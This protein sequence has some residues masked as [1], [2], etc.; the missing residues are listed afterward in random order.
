VFLINGTELP[1]AGVYRETL[2][3]TD[4]NKET[5][6][7]TVTLRC[8]DLHGFNIVLGMPWI[9][10]AQ[11]VFHWSAREW[12]YGSDDDGPKVRILAPQPFYASMRKP[13]ARLHAVS[14]APNSDHP[15][16]VALEAREEAGIPPE[17]EDLK[18]VFS[19][20]KAQ[21][22]AEHGL[23]NLT[24]NL[25]EGKEPPWGPIY[26][27]S[28]KVLE[29]L[30]D[31][32][33]EN[34][35]RNWIRPSTSSAGALV[36]FVPKKDGSLRLCVDYRGLN[37]F[38]RKN[39]YPL[40]LI[41]KA[42]DRLSGAKFYTKL[43]I[44][45]AYHRVRVAEGEEWK[46]AFRT[47]YG[48]YEYTDMPFSLANAP[49][50]F[51]SYINATL[52]PYLDVFVIAYLGDKVVYSNTV[53]EHRK[54]V[55]TVLE[56]LLKAGL[57]LKLRKYE[58]NAKEI[59]F[60][61]F[62]ITPKEVRMEKDR[63]ATIEEWPMPDSHRDIQV[64]LGFANFYRRFIKSFSGI[65]RPMTAMLKGGKEGKIFGPFEPTTEM[66]E[67]FRRLQSEFTKAPVLA[68]F[69]YEKPIRLETDASGFAIAGII[70][71]PAAWPTSGKEGRRVKDRDWHPIGFW[72]RTMADA[73]RNYSV[74][75]QEM[76][77][78]VEACRHWRHYMEGSKYPVR[79]L[80]DHHNLQGFMKDKPL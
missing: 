20:T 46:M 39:R 36:F 57:Y 49:A 7:Q 22:V 51:Q 8:V 37:Q 13:G 44:R 64:F 4:A 19:K 73:E 23:H 26:N 50:A 10:R 47:R 77:A 33:D 76:L 27:L 28:A 18:E 71:Q 32:L 42:I 78:I 72:S 62:I 68:H 69:D 3:I 6:L 63:I 30:R 55:R 31:Y 14:I 24:I 54:H 66:K 56:A 70:S 75:D 2:R 61:G 9:T 53:E 25:V 34:L 59:G 40:S 79:V 74:G 38:T 11:P 16:V 52:R 45:D 5:R 12:T 35:V 21:A 43:D 65:V 67:A 41:S 15:E 17:Y 58:F 48:H 60:V 29:T 1:I 80:T